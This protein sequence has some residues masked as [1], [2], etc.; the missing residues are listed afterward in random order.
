MELRLFVVL[1]VIGL[2]PSAMASNPTI[3]LY[4]IEGRSLSE[5]KRALSTLGPVG[6]DGVRHHGYT[7]WQVSWRF[8]T[9]ASGNTCRVTDLSTIVQST[10]TLPQWRPPEDAPVALVER[11]K[12]YRHAL[13][14]HEMGHHQFAVAA[15]DHVAQQ[16]H[17]L[18]VS[19]GCADLARELNERGKA[20]VEQQAQLEMEYDR[21][22]KHGV[23]QG[24]VL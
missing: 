19:S 18:R 16:L 13:E 1:L 22:T 4:E 8:K 2:S 3:D 11:W 5:L 10:I 6:K 24:A 23:T 9:E 21:H 14:E 7:K 15:A 17:A 20:I 12:R